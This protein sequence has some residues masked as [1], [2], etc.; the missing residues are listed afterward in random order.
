[1]P[2]EETKTMNRTDHIC[3]AI[4][5]CL[6]LLSSTWL[7]A[8][9]RAAK[10]IPAFPGA[11]GSGAYTPGG[12]GGKVYLV[13][14]LRD[15]DPGK[16]A[17]IPGSLR[18]AVEAK[19]PRTVVFRVS[20]YIDLTT[21]L[22]VRNPY[23]TIAGQTAPG[24]GV[25]LRYY[26]FVI[27]RTHDCIVR[28]L[29]CRTGDLTSKAGELDAITM[30]DVRNVIVDHCSATWATD[31]CLSV[32]RGA[33]QVTVQWCIIAECVTKHSYGSIIG[34]Y[35]GGLSFHHNLYANNR[36]R[37]PRPAAYNASEDHE[38]DPG[39]VIDF[40]NNVISNWSGLAGYA[41][42]GNAAH[43]ERTT[44]NY[45]GNYL[46][47]G[48][49]SP[50]DGPHRTSALTFYEGAQA[51]LHLAGNHLEGYAAGNA[52]NWRLVN[53]RR[54]KPTRLAEPPP[55]SPVTTDTAL[56]AYEKVIA[57]AG[58]T[59]PLRDAVDTRIV[60]GV[61]TNTGKVL[62][63]QKEVGGWPEYRSAVAPPD[64]DLDGMPDQWETRYG[65]DPG[66]ASDNSDD[67]DRDG[68]T[69]I[70]EFLNSTNPRAREGR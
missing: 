22:A 62:L 39:P 68:Y 13:T 55:V 20:G 21:N 60:E 49:S 7:P 48:P 33:D 27:G 12:R 63:S 58:A 30:W 56:A 29:R 52:D 15:Y 31:E 24:D 25:C 43:V 17:V 16:E 28:H 26:Q 64:R 45:V 34:S 6:T 2:I 53:D 1:M 32:T 61:R 40:R 4:S 37:N 50:K 57:G 66:N 42:S 35:D 69:N 36:S 18:E 11:E 3:P 46:K 70:E 41:G 5:L 44:I 65:L 8:E 10:R 54:R 67:A 9:D 38:D 59:L 51:K 47:P 19:G 14:T 23:I